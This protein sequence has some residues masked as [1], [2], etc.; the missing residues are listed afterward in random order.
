MLPILTDEYV[1]ALL[2]QLPPHTDV[3]IQKRGIVYVL[4]VDNR[5]VGVTTLTDVPRDR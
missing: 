3:V 4:V 2:E 1:K 5:D